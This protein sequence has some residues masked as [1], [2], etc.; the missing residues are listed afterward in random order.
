MN[1]KDESRRLTS[2]GSCDHNVDGVELVV[3]FHPEAIPRDQLVALLTRACER[4][5]TAEYEL[6]WERRESARLREKLARSSSQLLEGHAG[7]V[8]LTKRTHQTEERDPC[9]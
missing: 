9:E 7:N 3:R 6:E 2:S 8:L 1:S 4:L 5:A